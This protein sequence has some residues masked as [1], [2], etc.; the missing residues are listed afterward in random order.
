MYAVLSIVRRYPHR[1]NF[2][3]EITEANAEAQYRIARHMLACLKAETI[4]GL[5]LSP[6]DDDSDLPGQGGRAWQCIPARVFISRLR[7]YRRVSRQV[8]TK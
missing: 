7:D 2:P 5:S 3:W 6:A 1:F 4:W 8:G